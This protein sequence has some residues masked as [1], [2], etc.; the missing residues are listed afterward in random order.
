MRGNHLPHGA[1][2]GIFYPVIFKYSFAYVYTTIVYIVAFLQLAVMD[3]KQY[4]HEVALIATEVQV[5]TLWP[6][7]GAGE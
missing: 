5:V 3:F 6:A 7:C 1:T 4:M 2:Q